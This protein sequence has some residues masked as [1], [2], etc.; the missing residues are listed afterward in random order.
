MIIKKVLLVGAFN[1]KN[2]C[3]ANSFY[4]KFIELNY[5]TEKFN[6]RNNYL[7]FK[8]FKFINN[9]IINFLLIKK[10]DK[11]KPDLV[12]LLKAE[13]INLNTIKKIKEKK[14]LIV[15][16]YPDNIFALWNGNSNINVLKSLRYFDY[17]LSWGKFLKSSLISA[18]AKNVYYFPFAY[19]KDIYETNINISEQDIKKYKCDVC[20]AGTW[21][22][23][24][25][26]WLESL[27]KSMPDLN[28]AIWGNLWLENL[29][30]SSILINKINGPAVYKDELIKLFKSSKIILNFI[31]KQNLSSH[32]MR[33]LEVPA[34]KSFLL[35]ERTQEQASFLFKEGEDIE[36]FDN[37]QELV[38]KINYYLSNKSAREKI[39]DAS[40]KK[41]QDF[42][43]LIVLK[44]FMKYIQDQELL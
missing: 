12:F 9:K 33:T 22:K 24:R 28:L 44:K 6:Y 21:D 30:K 4:N 17:F 37:I 5:V 29:S 11:F 2:Y 25:E 42:E 31:R 19:D 7:I 32:N 43:L 41:V 23:E 14:I 10:I 38:F 18:G 13:N 3:Y 35:T 8:Y 1:N 15:N 36:C 40:H 16:F 27:C 39:I 20:F 26:I 34:T